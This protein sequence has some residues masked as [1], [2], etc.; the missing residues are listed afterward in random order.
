MTANRVPG[1]RKNVSDVMDHAIEVEVHDANW[2]IHRSEP[3]SIVTFFAYLAEK[4]A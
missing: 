1:K 3:H 2:A 4:G